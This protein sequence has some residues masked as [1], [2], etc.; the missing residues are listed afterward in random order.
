MFGISTGI[1]ALLVA[2]LCLV[3]A[4]EFVNG[5]NDTANAIAPVIYTRS[6]KPRRAVILAGFL[7]F[8]GVLLGGIGVAMAIMHLLPLS[9]IAEQPIS[10]GICVVAALLFSAII[11]NLTTWSLALP[12][13]SSHALIGSILGVSIAMIYLPIQ[14]SDSVSPNWHKALEVLE[15]LLFSP[16]IGFTIALLLMFI[17]YKVIDSK[18]YFKSPKKN[19][20]I[21]KPGK[22]LRSL[23][24][25]TSAW[26]SFAHGSNDGQKGV[27]IAMLILISLLPSM[28]AIN[29]AVNRE[30]LKTDVNFIS[31]VVNEI[32]IASINDESQ[33]KMIIDA[34]ENITIFNTIIAGENNNMKVRDHILKIQKDLSNIVGSNFSF[35]NKANADSVNSKL[36]SS[37][38]K[39]HIDNISKSVDYAPIWIIV[40]ISM[41][42]GLG[43]MI[44]R[45]RIV[46]TIGEGIGDKKMNYAQ[47][48]NSALIT[49]VTITIASRLGLP[50]S[51]T[52]VLSSSVAGS[53]VGSKKGGIQGDTIKHIVLAW[54]LTLPVTIMLSATLFVTFWYLFVK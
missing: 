4:F 31:S 19:K 50:V 11:W 52:H 12:A 34:K 36:Q 14:G 7:N 44:G 15:S 39:S 40:M 47:A 54:V 46:T 48:T 5:F 16:I 17:S 26:V 20:K 2:C 38:L 28:F 43:T 9:V 3:C 35:I 53:M 10:F 22:G 33:K 24:I 32:D 51:T 37:E 1:F 42:I 41:S 6:L 13:S 8:L 45:K 25:A 27:G 23:L 29:P 30:E 21:E 49:A 18:G